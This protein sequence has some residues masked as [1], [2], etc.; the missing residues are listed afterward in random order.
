MN[1]VMIEARFFWYHNRFHFLFPVVRKKPFTQGKLG[2]L[3]FDLFD[4]NRGTGLEKAL[5]VTATSKV[6]KI[7][8]KRD[9]F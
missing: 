1:R 5:A 3:R 6:P 4:K 8:M 9:L 7:Y 2:T